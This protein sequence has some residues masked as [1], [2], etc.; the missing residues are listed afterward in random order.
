MHMRLAFKAQSQARATIET[1]AEIKNPHQFAFVK[2]A[3]IFAVQE[4]LS[5][6]FSMC[7]LGVWGPGV[8]IDANP[9]DPTLFKSG[10]V[11]WRVIIACDVAL[12]CDPTAFT[13]ATSIT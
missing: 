1:S 13:K 8:T 2:Q 5:G 11:Q 4:L 3:N 9:Y 10:V 6:P 12:G 7:H